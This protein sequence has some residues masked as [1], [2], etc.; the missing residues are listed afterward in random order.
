MLTQL[1]THTD[2]HRCTFPSPPHK[3]I[4]SHTLLHTDFPPLATPFLFCI[5]FQLSEGK[6]EASQ[7]PM[8]PV[9]TGLALSQ[10]G[11]HPAPSQA[12]SSPEFCKQEL[13]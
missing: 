7:K 5:R 13:H 12:F 6:E 1:Y 3:C 9:N 2:A 10:T 11:Q 4:L 8:T